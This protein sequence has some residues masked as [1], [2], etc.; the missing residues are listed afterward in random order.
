MP[1]ID[2]KLDQ[3]PLDRPLRLEHAG[4]AIVVIRTGDK[5]AAFPDRCPH[6]H[7][8]LSEGEVINGLLQ[9]PGHGLEFNIATGRCVNS[10]VYRLKPL[11]V[12]VWDD[13]VRIDWDQPASNSEMKAEKEP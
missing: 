5:I 7:W 12:A 2:V 1:Q 3:I 6:A 13:H 8:P 9:C 11:S 4:T 10:P